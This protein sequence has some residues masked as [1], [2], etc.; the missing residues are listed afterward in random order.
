MKFD[1]PIEK[2]EY[3]FEL[4][5]DCKIDITIN[6]RA[7]IG[8][9]IH[10]HLLKGH[11]LLKINFTKSDPTATESYATLKKFE[12]NGGDFID[13][14]KTLEYKVDESKHQKTVGKLV[15]NLYFGYIGSMEIVL[16]QT[17]DQLRKAAWTIADK[18]FEYTKWPIKGN[19]HRNKDFDTVLRDAKFMY[20]G[21]TPPNAKAITDVVNDTKLADLR[22]PCPNDIGSKLWDWISKSQRVKMY[23]DA[24]KH[25]TFSNGVSDSLESF[26]RKSSRVIMMPGK[27][28]HIHGELFDDTDLIRL[29]PFQRP[30][31]LYADVLLEYPSPWYTNQELDDVIKQAK[32]KKAKIALDLTWLPVA[33]DEIQLD[34][35]GIDQIFFSM[36]KAWPIHDLRPAFR[37]SRER[38]N[39]RQTFDYEIG[40]YPKTSVNMFMKLIDKFSF[41]HI[42]ET[43]KDARAK[44]MQTFN[45]ES[46]PVLWFTKH[47]SAIHD[48]KGHI[49]KHYFLDEFVCIQ[50]LLDFKGKYWW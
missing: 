48:D 25:F 34:L 46:T 18:E 43:V 9:V 21:S 42:Y 36:N 31:P 38:I 5:G 12:V 49:S 37:W 8:N 24:F 11:N 50:K 35:N 16:E 13:K 2:V 33:T 29:D 7:V 41:G 45:L 1:F 6:E 47:E 40:M 23:G 19:K 32:D 26:V 39:D 20:T 17:N 10:G 22:G 28:Y 4:I 30:I 14:V 44:I 15:N 3:E 27:M